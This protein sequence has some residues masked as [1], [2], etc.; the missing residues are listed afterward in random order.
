MKRDWNPDEPEMMD[1]P[2]PVS[3]ELERDLENLR[4]LNRRFGSY[5][6]V[7]RFLERWLAPGRS[8]R[9]LDLCTGFGDIPRMALDWSRERGIAL[10]MDAVDF[11][12]ATLEIARSRSAAYP[13]IRFLQADARDF[14][15]PECGESQ[16]PRYDLVF[17]SLALHHFSEADA[18]RI[19]SRCRALAQA[20]G[21]RVLVADLERSRVNAFGIWLVTE[22]I[23]RDAMTKFDARLSARRAFSFDEFRALA[24]SAGWRDF[25]HQRF[26][27]SRQ[28]I[29]I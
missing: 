22:L 17:C 10:T 13:E 9:A 25:G 27:P 24:E 21:A 5:A 20:E 15:P 12:P 18:V 16:P 11:H 23:Y 2:Q 7:R 19:L 14:E 1:R 26:F 4:G 3:P 6:L 8:Y 29:W 28:A